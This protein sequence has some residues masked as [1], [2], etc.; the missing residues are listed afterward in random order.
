VRALIACRGPSAS[1]ATVVRCAYLK[2]T[3]HACPALCAHTRNVASA[4]VQLVVGAKFVQHPKAMR[5]RMVC[6]DEQRWV[7]PK[8]VCCTVVAM[9]CVV[10]ATNSLV[11]GVTFTS[12]MEINR[13][14]SII[15]LRHRAA[16]CDRCGDATGCVE[17]SMLYL[18]TK[19]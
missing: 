11:P 18:S 10:P 16:F 1:H 3:F 17:W 9:P 6:Y 2:E 13:V 5:V 4:R 14:G 12:I 7:S 15:A 19:S 8:N